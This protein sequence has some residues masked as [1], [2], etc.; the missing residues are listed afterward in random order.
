MK[1]SGR[2]LVNTVWYHLSTRGERTFFTTGCHE[3]NCSF[4]F[5]LHPLV[6]W[7]WRAERVTL[8]EVTRVPGQVNGYNSAAQR[9]PQ[10]HEH[11]GRCF[12]KILKLRL[13]VSK[14]TL[15]I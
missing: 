12:W 13:Y 6:L 10:R 1:T 11:R 8:D 15:I 14:D 9:P 5:G 2:D 3:P 7:P 4:M